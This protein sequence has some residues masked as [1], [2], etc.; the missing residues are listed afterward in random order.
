MSKKPQNKYAY[1]S[2]ILFAISFLLL[3]YG[4][5]I[6]YYNDHKLID[7]INDII[8][9]KNS[10]DNT[11]HIETTEE[12]PVITTPEDSSNETTSN[13]NTASVPASPSTSTE[14]ELEI[15]SSVI[16]DRDNSNK[17]LTIE[18]VNNQ[19]RHELQNQY[20]ITIRYG[21]ETRGYTV[22]GISTEI[23][24]DASIINSQLVR[25]KQALTVYPEGLFREIRNGGIPLTI[26]L[27]NK[28]SDSTVTGVTDSSY[29]DAT[30]SI[31]ASYTFEDS[32]YHESYH[33][34]ERYLFKK[35]ANYNTWDNL[36]PPEFQGWG[37]IDGSLSYSN[38]FSD[39]APF[40]NNYA[41]TEASE[42]RA[43]TFEYMMAPSK[44]SC[45]NNGNVVW[46]KAKLI[47]DTMDLVLSSVRPDE[48]EYWERFL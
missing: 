3:L 11:I 45:L 7:P 17:V 18:E 25:L 20:G 42:D 28:Y 40:V 41:Q 5:G 29:S 10:N 35:G 38:T 8:I 1:Y 23:I 6:D 16:K 46:L 31:S 34:I 27:I 37:V 12:T 44:A 26:L 2:K 4:L 33:Y 13:D 14:K 48:T 47:A 32:F 22:A 15:E 39:T 36:N 24:T 30:I 19:L 21:E 43:S 9:T